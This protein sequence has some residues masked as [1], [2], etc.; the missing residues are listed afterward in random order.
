[1]AGVRGFRLG[2]GWLEVWL[3]AKVVMSALFGSGFLWIHDPDDKFMK[4]T[5]LD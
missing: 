1:V 4:I 3:F 2:S 5:K